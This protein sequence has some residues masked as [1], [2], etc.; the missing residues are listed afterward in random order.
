MKAFIYCSL[1]SDRDYEDELLELCIIGD[2]VNLICTQQSK[3]VK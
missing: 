2:D 3:L 1:F